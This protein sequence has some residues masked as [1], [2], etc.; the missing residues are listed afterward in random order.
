MRLK[1]K[2]FKDKKILYFIAWHQARNTALS[3]KIELVYS[4]IVA[5]KTIPLTTNT[6]LERQL[7]TS[8]SLETTK[9]HSVRI[10]L[11]NNSQKIS[12]LT[13][14]SRVNA[15]TLLMYFIYIQTNVIMS[16]VQSD[17]LQKK[18]SRNFRA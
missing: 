15:S 8:L 10:K 4:V 7:A 11:T 5:N 2:Q 16:V 9:C 14:A 6:T 18:P 12:V 13:I 1:E 17:L 3:I